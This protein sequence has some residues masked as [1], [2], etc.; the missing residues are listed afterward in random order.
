VTTDPKRDTVPVLRSYLYRFNTAFVGLTGSLAD[1]KSAASALHLFVGGTKRLPSGGYDV[2]HDTAVIGL[3]GRR[4][5]VA[6]TQGTSVAAMA[7]DI[8]TL[9]KS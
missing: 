4:A 1:I 6:W 7:A 8:A 2:A 9:Q 5:V 3:Q